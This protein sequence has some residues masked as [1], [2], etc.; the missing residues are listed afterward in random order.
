MKDVSTAPRRDGRE[1]GEILTE[2]ELKALILATVRGHDTEG[3]GATEADLQ[4]VADWAEKVRKEA[5]LLRLILSGE[6]LVTAV[7]EDGD[8]SVRTRGR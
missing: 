1:G 3:R 6:V 8:F 4:A 2:E 5:A 7:E